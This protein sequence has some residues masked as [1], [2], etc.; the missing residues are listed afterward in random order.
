M[1][2]KK[3]IQYF[4]SN[5]GVE[6]AVLTA[7]PLPLL[8]LFSEP[9]LPIPFYAKLGLTCFSILLSI[10]FAY[11][12]LLKPLYGKFFGIVS[13][14]IIY[15]LAFPL[16][17][18]SPFYTLIANVLFIGILFLII[19]I[20]PK[21]Q[22]T[23]KDSD[24]WRCY[25][26]ASWSSHTLTLI[27]FVFV[28]TEARG[29]TDRYTLYTLFTSYAV[30]QLTF[31]YWAYYCG[32]KR[33]ILIGLLMLAVG[34]FTVYHS[35][36]LTIYILLFMNL[37]ASSILFVD[38]RQSERMI[39]WWDVIL[40]HPARM[41][42]STF[43]LLCLAGSLVLQLPAATTGEYISF[44]DAVFTSVSAVCVTGLIV[45]DTPHDFTLMGQII[46]LILIQLGGLGIMSITT[47]ALQ[48][49]G[50]RLSLKHE[51]V[52]ASMTETDHKSLINSLSIILKYT[53]TLELIGALILGGLFMVTG[54]TFSEALW[55]GVFTAV[56][57]FCN[58]GFALQS[59]SLIAYN[60]QPLVLNTVAVLIFLGGMAPAAALSIPYII[61]RKRVP[62]S[63]KLAVYASV[64]LVVTGMSAILA[65]EWN[66]SLRGLNSIDKVWN[67]L[68]Q[69]V[70]LR[71]AGFNSIDLYNVTSPT[72]IIMH[73]FMFIGGSPGGTA[74]G[75]K[76][77]TM[78]VLILTFWSNIT[79][80]KTVVFNTY[81][82][83]EETIYKAVTIIIAGFIVWFIAVIMVEVT[84]LIPTRELIYEVTSAIGTVGLSL[85]ATSKLDA[86]G[87][88]IIVIT[89]F[90]GRIGPVT[91]F[92]FISGSKT[93]GTEHIE[94]N[95][96]LS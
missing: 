74:G 87:K 2:A 75:I 29:I 63:Y 1:P 81:R 15:I 96:T 88:L 47:I 44:I 19:D 18:T 26:R 39:Y 65:F 45:L 80:R 32:I 92:T 31:I 4:I 61:R 17:N 69:S 11:F 72:L 10:L 40:L 42:F 38:K 94:K 56:S 60:S 95:I 91:M 36:E 70:T 24:A 49:F 51:T 85:G 53:F 84:Q 37:T 27:L 25:T 13:I 76:T 33:N 89:M 77:T 14:I 22:R 55:R 78:A 8:L 20:Q 59:D 57:A 21:K 64:F 66:V 30:S 71:T 9:G 12:I 48:S 35:S 43:F 50:K 54:D 58:A 86:I 3:L 83:S 6:W 93:T 41:L 16:V 34:I 67:A 46:I 73:L 52:L 28:I 7:S 82:I 90:A 62:L 68:F 79:N 5:L 23:L